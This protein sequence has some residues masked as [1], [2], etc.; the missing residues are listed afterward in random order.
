M[1]IFCSAQRKETIMAMQSFY[2]EIIEKREWIFSCNLVD[3]SLQ[4]IKWVGPYQNLWVVTIYNEIDAIFR[5]KSNLKR[6]APIPKGLCNQV[7]ARV[8][9][10]IWLISKMNLS[11]KLRRINP[12]SRI[13]LIFNVSKLKSKYH[14][15]WRTIFFWVAFTTFCYCHWT[16]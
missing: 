13:L 14:C 16:F 6:Y 10:E 4:N 7:K 15:S 2:Y 1:T 8:L 5:W 9:I 3:F 11:L 12:F